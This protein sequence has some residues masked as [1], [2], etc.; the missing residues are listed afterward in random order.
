M[1]DLKT[2]S[3]R[4]SESLHAGATAYAEALG[5]PLNALVSVALAEYLGARTAWR[6]GGPAELV[7][8]PQSG[9]GAG[10]AGPA[11][12]GLVFNATKVTRATESGGSASDRH[13]TEAK[14][15]PTPS[16]KPIPR[17]GKAQP[18]PCGSGKPYGK[19]HG[20]AA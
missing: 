3:I 18:C 17:V 5:I 14:A 16:G 1:S 12:L 19:C 10:A 9:D 7:T 20:R 13:Q 4:L 2:T 6:A 11:P 15:S 8:Q